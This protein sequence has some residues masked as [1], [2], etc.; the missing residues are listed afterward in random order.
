VRKNQSTEKTVVADVVSPD[1]EF[2]SYHDK[3][4]RDLSRARCRRLTDAR[5]RRLHMKTGQSINAVANVAYGRDPVAVEMKSRFS[6]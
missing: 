5:D 6:S 4:K 2:K 1:F 3:V